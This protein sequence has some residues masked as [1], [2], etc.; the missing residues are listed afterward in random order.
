MFLLICDAKEQVRWRPFLSSHIKCLS[1]RCVFHQCR[2]T[3]FQLNCL[4]SHSRCLHVHDSTS[5]LTGLSFLQDCCSWWASCCTPQA[6]VQT[7][8]RVTAGLRRRPSSPLCALWAGRS[9]QPSEERWPASCALSCLHRLRSPPPAR[10]FKR[11]LR[12]ARV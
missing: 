11:K 12:R 1:N 3:V 7:R 5:L 8:C 4:F 6:G 2:V 10:K 9:T